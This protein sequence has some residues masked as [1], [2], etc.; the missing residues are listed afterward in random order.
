MAENKRFVGR[1]QQKH[2]IE[3]NWLQA[4]NFI[5]LAGE[6]IIYDVEVDK[7]GAP[8]ALP[9]GRAIP[10][11]YERSKIGDGFTKVNDLPFVNDK[12]IEELQKYVDDTLLN[13]EW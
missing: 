3:A 10:Y 1:I 11:T 9:E 7:D 5:P 2:D 6:L 13:G 4:T 12:I 8:L